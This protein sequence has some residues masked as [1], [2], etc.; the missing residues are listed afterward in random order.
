[1][2]REAWIDGTILRST[3]IVFLRGSCFGI[4][5]VH[6]QEAMRGGETT[7]RLCFIVFASIVILAM[8]P[9]GKM[10]AMPGG[11]L[12]G[13]SIGGTYLMTDGDETTEL[14][15]AFERSWSPKSPYTFR[16]TSASFVGSGKVMLYF[17]NSENG[18]LSGT[19][20]FL[21]EGTKT[22]GKPD[23]ANNRVL[24]RG[25]AGT[26]VKEIDLFGST[27]D[28]SKVP[29]TTPPDQVTGL[30]G[31]AGDKKVTLSWNT[32]AASDF[33]SYNVYQDGTKVLSVTSNS[34]TITG[35]TN[36]QAY[37]FQVSAVDKTGNESVKSSQISL[38][39]VAPP[40]PDTT[41]PSVPTLKGRPGNQQA[42]LE[43]TKPSDTDLAGYYLYQDGVK[44]KTLTDTSTTVVGLEN[45][46]QYKFQVSAFDKSGNESAKS[47]TINITPA[48]RIDVVLIPNGDSIVVQI[49]GGSKPYFIDW[50]VA[51]KT[52]NESQYTIENLKFDTE[53][54]VTVTDAGGLTYTQTINTGTEKG[55]IPPTF[56]N[57]QELFQRMLDV[58]GTAGT[59]AVAIIGGA[60]LLGIMVVLARWAWI[61]LRGWLSR[62]K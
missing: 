27:T 51:Q 26:V 19:I 11:L 58:F 35:L 6:D 46:T 33:Q 37:R 18:S 4:T 28:P 21:E 56:P 45:G 59:I 9:I 22:Y 61:M 7:R 50:G 13:E 48:N 40:P 62:A 55:F 8:F 20:E 15:G 25:Y 42:L 29:D 49:V 23:V 3:F 34:A 32:S 17:Y 38:T 57:P 44:V 31:S 36:G 47:N 30:T 16:V 24:I 5:P 52:V 39:P 41:P 10:Y 60:L 14:T 1:M 53:Y 43:W 12:N 54:T 2:I